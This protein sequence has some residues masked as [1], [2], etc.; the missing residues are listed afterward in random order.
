MQDPDPADALEIAL[1]DVPIAL[2][3]GVSADERAQAQT[4]LVS[5]TITR[6]APQRFV[7]NTALE[8]TLDY[9]RLIALLRE[10]VPRL[11][12]YLLIEAIAEDVA[13]GALALDGAARH[14]AV[15]VKKPSVL[16]GQG[17]VSATL[18]R[19]RPMRIGPRGGRT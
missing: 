3:L 7:R 9:D 14:V 16:S 4:I 6:E 13:A 18:R 11:G 19:A 10:D 2:H 5:L 17:L 15:T 8:D 1:I 12:P